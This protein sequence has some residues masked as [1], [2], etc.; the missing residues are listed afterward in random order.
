MKIVLNTMYGLAITAMAG[1]GL[2]F[3]ATLFPVLGVEVKVVKSGSMEPAIPV[4]GLVIIH[5][6]ASYGVGDVITF[7]ADTK[8]Q[9]PTTHRI[10]AVQGQGASQ[11]FQTKGDANNAVDPTPVNLAE[12]HGKV[13]ISIP[14][15][16]YVLAFA[17]TPFGFG[18]LVGLPALMIVVEEGYSIVREVMRL[19]RRRTS[20]RAGA[21]PVGTTRLVP[22]GKVSVM[23]GIKRP[24]QQVPQAMRVPVK[25]IAGTMVGLLVVA[26]GAF[27]SNQGDTAAV[28]A[29]S[30]VSQA[31]KFA[32]ADN[33]GTELFR[34][35]SLQLLGDPPQEEVLGDQTETIVDEPVVEPTEPKDE[36]PED[37]W[38]TLVLDPVPAPEQPTE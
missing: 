1:V 38:E 20:P 10:A 36:S 23:D 29:D 9:I 34:V 14:Y 24:M 2:L 18:L 17:R 26:V 7:G 25:H 4:G 16:G 22:T 11:M 21:S 32:A 31:N 13:L 27:M 3:V 8:T 19:R 28:Y 35:S 30:E 5:P 6:A 12:V 15:L 37:P 33:Y